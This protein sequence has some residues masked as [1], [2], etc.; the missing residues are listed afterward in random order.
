[1]FLGLMPRWAHTR[2]QVDHHVKVKKDFFDAIL[3]YINEG[4]ETDRKNIEQLL[5]KKKFMSKQ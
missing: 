2:L 1:M 4:P 5:L 3:R